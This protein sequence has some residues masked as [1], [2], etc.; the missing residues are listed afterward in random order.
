[1]PPTDYIRPRIDFEEKIT[2]KMT[3]T[4]TRK[5]HK[6]MLLANTL[7]G[8]SPVKKISS[9]YAYVESEGKSIKSINQVKKSDEILVHVADGKM[10]AVVTEVNKN[11]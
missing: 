5:Q 3:K 2:D 7:D 6:L 11:E 1:M 10:K 4:W 8:L 9:G